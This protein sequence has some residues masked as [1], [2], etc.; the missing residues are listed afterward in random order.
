MSLK[1]AKEL[2][3]NQDLLLALRML[4]DCLQLPCKDNLLGELGLCLKTRSIGGNLLAD[5]AY[6]WVDPRVSLA[7]TTP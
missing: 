4:C 7:D 3:L 6:A 2:E 1:G 5:L